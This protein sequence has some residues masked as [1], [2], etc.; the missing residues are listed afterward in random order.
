MIAEFPLMRPSRELRV[1]TKGCACPVGQTVRYASELWG[2]TV[3]FSAYAWA[4][5]GMLQELFE[6]AKLR[7]VPP[8]RNGP[9]NGPAG[10]RVSATRQDVTGTNMSPCCPDKTAQPKTK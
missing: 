7:E 2:A 3:T 4:L 8:A 1:D 10:L 6:I 5:E 9:P